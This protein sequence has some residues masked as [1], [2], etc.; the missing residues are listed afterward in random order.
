M[1]KIYLFLVILL[2]MTSC[3]A[4]TYTVTFIDDNVKLLT[5]EVKKGKTLGNV[6][7]PVKEGYIFLSWLKD[8]LEYN[9]NNPINEDMV[10]EA[11]WTEIPNP[12][13]TYTITFD[14]GD[15]I[16]TVNVKEGEKVA[17]PKATPKKEKHKFL[18][19][20]IGET[21]YDFDTPVTKDLLI[22]AKFEKN[23]INIKYD[24]DGGTGTIEV[25]IEK[26]T[27][28]DKPKN[29]LKFG[30]TF[31]K[32]TI[33]GEEYN[34]DKALNKDTIIKANYEANIYVKVTFDTDGG[35]IINSKMLIAGMTLEELPTPKKEGYVFDYWEYNGERFNIETKI[36]E[37]I[38][39]IAKYQENNI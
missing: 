19:W 27:I 39:L 11:S 38:T 17:L 20:Y 21:P 18:G 15:E 9:I 6:E 2:V 23:R 13:K 14:F 32:W 12:V 7:T 4:K 33:D 5:V 30:Y 8:G 22:V 3:K 26:G 35:E 10:L 34:F 25:E 36:N 16:K 37:D 28:P 1:K 29:P 24:L 31:K